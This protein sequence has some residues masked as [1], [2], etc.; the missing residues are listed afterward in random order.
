MADVK[1]RILSEDQTKSGLDKVKKTLGTV[2]AAVASVT[3]AVYAFKK[4]FDFAEEGAQ[5]LLTEQ[6][7]GR[8][9]AT[10]NTTSD[11]LK[12]DLQAAMGGIVSETEA[13][14]LG[15][16]LL[17]LGLVKSSEEATR[18]A[19]VVGQLGMDMNQLVLT[20]TNQTT[21]RFDALGVSVDGF[22]EKVKA[23]EEA[24]HDTNEAFRLAFLEQAED[25]V[26][27]VGSVTDT[28]AGEFMKLKASM[29]D[30]FDEL[31]KGAAEAVL[32][33]VR[34]INDH[35]DG[36]DVLRKAVEYGVITQS[37]FNDIIA[38]TSRG[39]KSWNEELEKVTQ[40]M[41]EY[42]DMVAA[43]GAADQL[44]SNYLKDVGQAA[45][46]AGDAIDY[47]SDKQYE[48]AIAKAWM[49]EPELVE[50][51]RTE[52]EAAD[53]TRRAIEMLIA[54]EQAVGLGLSADLMIPEREIG[55]TGN[56]GKV[57]SWSN[58]GSVW[59]GEQTQGWASL[60]KAEGGQLGN[61][62]LV[63]ERGAEMI[64]G[65]TVIPADMTR[66]LINLGLKPDQKYGLGGAIGAGNIY[67]PPPDYSSTNDMPTY[68]T[69]T[70]AAAGAA[71]AGS[72]PAVTS[73]SAA[74]TE[75][76]AQTARVVSQG[77]TQEITAAATV[78]SMKLLAKQDETNE[79][80]RRLPTTQDMFNVMKDA[81]A[82]VIQ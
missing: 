82:Q 64:I 69:E 65:N 3:A 41:T 19:A 32:P 67:I 5:L 61:I 44:F 1:I 52:R 24:G 28:V 34:A 54:V 42:E 73:I 72:V 25:Q 13:L 23:L 68:F 15:T 18:M 57:Y 53:K 7:F 40:Q 29:K 10:I 79:L 14:A 38:D 71:G 22:K 4:G 56:Y 78:D 45:I 11:A 59:R 39:I 26:A 58:Q 81:L 74:A 21:M 35:N 37:D 63:G 76:A 80:L 75:A 50:G 16:D 33:L 20:L 51:L 48:H 70:A 2:T 9:A 6:K 27:K 12:K 31:K 77:M 43:A 36:M 17:S 55:L 46:E 60:A 62:N 49:D 66:R 8:L 47:L 30:S